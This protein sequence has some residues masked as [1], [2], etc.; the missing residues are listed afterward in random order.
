MKMLW[1]HILQQA[2]DDQDEAL[3]VLGPSPLCLLC[4]S[5]SSIPWP[6][7]WWQKLV[8][9][10][11]PPR[12]PGLGLVCVNRGKDKDQRQGLAG[13]LSQQP[14]HRTRGCWELPGDMAHLSPCW[15]GEW[16]RDWRSCLLSCL[17]G[18]VA[19]ARPPHARAERC[20]PQAPSWV[21]WPLPAAPGPGQAEG[22]PSLSPPTSESLQERSGFA[23]ARLRDPAQQMLRSPPSPP[24]SCLPS[25]PLQLKE[26][27][28][29]SPLPGNLDF[30][31]VFF[32]FEERG[33][34]KKKRAS[35]G[36]GGKLLSPAAKPLMGG[37][38]SLPSQARRGSQ[39]QSPARG[40][41][42]RD[43]ALSLCLD[44]PPETNPATSVLLPHCF[45]LC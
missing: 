18:Q 14:Q 16:K 15:H 12:N 39:C 23:Q 24:S 29:H 27:A 38:S 8:I 31:A 25:H 3:G 41:E 32:L 11:A 30:S 2:G 4:H 21:H 10:A 28:G 13:L 26:A 40:G 37:S 36:C 34:K 44:T 1:R 17:A 43:R 20:P 42:S 35:R 9:L 7:A 5:P 45:I 19:P 6:W 22:T 33:G